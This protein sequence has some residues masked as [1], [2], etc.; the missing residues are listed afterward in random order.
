M[1]FMTLWNLYIC[2]SDHI[3]LFIHLVL[4]YVFDS[5]LRH[6]IAFFMR[7]FHSNIIGTPVDHVRIL[8]SFVDKSVKAI[9]SLM[10]Q[11]NKIP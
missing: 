4:I 10:V 5:V 11:R 9:K 7:C 2:I 8:V 6:A 3:I 1:F